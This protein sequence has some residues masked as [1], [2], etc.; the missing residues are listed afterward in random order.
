MIIIFIRGG[1]SNLTARACCH[2]FEHFKSR[3]KLIY[4]RFQLNI[5]RL[6]ERSHFKNSVETCVNSNVEMFDF[7]FCNVMSSAYSFEV[8][9]VLRVIPKKYS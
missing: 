9:L 5:I 2:N 3:V 8:G 6:S 7:T 1:E 4:L